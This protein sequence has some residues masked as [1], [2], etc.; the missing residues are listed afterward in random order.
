MLRVPQL[1]NGQS[2]T[3]PP[4]LVPKE[5]SLLG[6]GARRVSLG[7]AK[8]SQRDSQDGCVTKDDKRDAKVVPQEDN[9]ALGMCP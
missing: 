5:P 3:E 9:A 2:V 7:K 1:E 6:K 8:R 4:G